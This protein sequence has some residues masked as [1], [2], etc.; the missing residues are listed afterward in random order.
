MFVVSGSNFIASTPT[1]TFQVMKPASWRLFPDIYTYTKVGALPFQSLQNLKLGLGIVK[2]FPFQLIG[3]RM[4]RDTLFFPRYNNLLLHLTSTN[5]FYLTS[6]NVF[7]LTSASAFHLTSASMFHFTSAS[8]F[9][10]TSGSVFHLTPVFLI[11]NHHG[12]SDCEIFFTLSIFFFFFD[13][14]VDRSGKCSTDISRS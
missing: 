9:H 11:L 1:K 13:F 7:H 3:K 6:T 12:D 5:V 4:S 2:T 10:L 8:L 14:R